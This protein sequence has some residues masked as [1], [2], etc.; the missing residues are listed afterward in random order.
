LSSHEDRK[1]V[2]QGRKKLMAGAKALRS[3]K[4]WEGLEVPI[5]LTF[6]L[7][8]HFIVGGSWS[9]LPPTTNDAVELPAFGEIAG[10]PSSEATEKPRP[11]KPA[12]RSRHLP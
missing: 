8:D 3:G 5:P 11:W 10:L 7:F 12:S 2:P 4:E 1:A 9:A 6:S